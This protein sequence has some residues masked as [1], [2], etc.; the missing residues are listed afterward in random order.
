MKKFYRLLEASES[1]SA[2]TLQIL[3]EQKAARLQREIDSGNPSAKE[4]LWALRQAFETLS[5]PDKRE[6]YD[7][8][9]SS[10]SAATV[11]RSSA[12][13]LRDGI[14]WK[15]TTILLGLLG[16]G[17]VGFGLQIASASKKDENKVELLKVVRTTDNDATRAASERVLVEGTL[18]N[19][20]KAI[21]S[22]GQIS[23]RIV[24]VEETAEMRRSRELEYR[25]AAAAEQLR[26]QQARIDIGNQ[27]LQWERR[28]Q[29]QAL[30]LQQA[31]AR[32]AADRMSTIQIMLSGGRI[33]EARTYAIS[34]EERAAVESAEQAR[35]ELHRSLRSQR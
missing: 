13:P 28:Q 11:S 32:M 6:A 3:F 30:A 22:Q 12:P 9:F 5:D 34:T 1:A 20:E 17:V 27:Q 33:D 15:M 8:S 4:Q 18:Q 26:Q 23:N 25:A 16:A 2:E 31:K 7:L 19:Q 10:R 24:N 35:R 21:D 29:E 14:S